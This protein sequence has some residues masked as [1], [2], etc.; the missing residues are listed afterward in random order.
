MLKLLILPESLKDFFLYM[1]K[2]IFLRLILIFEI[3]RRTNVSLKRFSMTNQA[4]YHKN[5]GKTVIL[6]VRK[7]KSHCGI[8]EPH[9]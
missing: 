7:W 5:L 3:G 6:S 4:D 9:I 1:Y 8:F 2:L